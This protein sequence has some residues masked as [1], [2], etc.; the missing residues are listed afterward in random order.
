MEYVSKKVVKPHKDEFGE[1][2]KEIRPN[3]KKERITFTCRLVGSGKRNLVVR[4]H[5]KGF[6]CDYQIIIQKNKKNLNEEDLKKL[7]IK[8]FDK[9]VTKRGFKNCE[10]SARAITIKKVDFENSKILQAYDVV[11][12]DQRKDGYYILSNHKSENYY[13]YEKLPNTEKHTENAE[14][15]KGAEM[16]NYLRKIYLEKKEKNIEDKKSFQ[17]FNEAVNDTLVQFDIF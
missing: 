1:I 17:L 8:E 9:S 10:D 13:D 2:I 16:W 6:D 14:K 4:H 5:N 7:F 12:L 15:I 3:I 11:I